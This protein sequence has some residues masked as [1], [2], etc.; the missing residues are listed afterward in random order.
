MDNVKLVLIDTATN[1][2]YIVQ[3]HIGVYDTSMVD[4]AVSSLANKIRA[5]LKEIDQ[6]RVTEVYK[7]DDN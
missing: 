1:K 4:L 7:R 5:K 2:E 3:E 6:D